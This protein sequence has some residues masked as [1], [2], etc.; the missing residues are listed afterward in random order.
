MLR[1]IGLIF[2]FF[3]PVMGVVWG[4]WG[5]GKKK[6]REKKPRSVSSVEEDEQMWG[7]NKDCD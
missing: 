7:F 1:I 4:C 5:F 6:K 2:A 3:F